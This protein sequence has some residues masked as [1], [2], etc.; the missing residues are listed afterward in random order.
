[1][2]VHYWYIRLQPVQHDDGGWDGVVESGMIVLWAAV[3]KKITSHKFETCLS[4][5]LPE[6]SLGA[7]VLFPLANSSTLHSHCPSKS[8]FLI[9]QVNG[10]ATYCIWKVGHPVEK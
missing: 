4:P 1:M 8:H 2:Q 3:E 5:T 9:T 7:S 10:T 6:T